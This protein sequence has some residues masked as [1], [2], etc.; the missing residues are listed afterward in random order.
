[1]KSHDSVGKN[2]SVVG[3]I[4]CSALVPSGMLGNLALKVPI[5]E[6]VVA[7]LKVET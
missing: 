6:E 4:A 3:W 1:M 5:L 7:F 2:K